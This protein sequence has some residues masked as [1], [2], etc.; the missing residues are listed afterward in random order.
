MRTIALISC[1]KKKLKTNK[2]V[3][4]ENLYSP[5]TLFSTSLKYARMRNV[6]Q[7]AILSAKHHLLGLDTWIKPYNKTLKEMGKEEIEAWYSVTGD[8]LYYYLIGNKIEK[9]ILLAGKK[10]YK[11]L[12]PYIKK[13]GCKI[14]LPL[15]GMPIGE[16][17]A[18]MK[19]EI[20]QENIRSL[21]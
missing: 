11:G 6:D 10:Y 19:E 3:S 5:S 20:K 16:R 2:R 1:S 12:I 14:L 7:I 18:F 4:A 8:A 15:K 21:I 13:T 9:V 17:V